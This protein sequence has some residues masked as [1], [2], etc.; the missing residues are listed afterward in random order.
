MRSLLFFGA[1]MLAAC[2]TSTLQSVAIPYD[3][4]DQPQRGGVSVSYTNSS[5]RALCLPPS[6]W[7]TE[8]GFMDAAEDRVFLRIGSR[9]YSMKEHNVGYCPDCA[10]RV[11]P[12]VTL[13][14]FIPYQRFHMPAEFANQ[15]K[16]LEFSP[17]AYPCPRD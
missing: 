14:T 16:Q 4:V 12:G 13:T 3:F 1:L 10:T 7:P 8:A 2:A 17:I 6:Q 9:R 5:A 11:N 15:P